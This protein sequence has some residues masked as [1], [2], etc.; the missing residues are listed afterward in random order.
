MLMTWLITAGTLLVAVVVIAI[1]AVG[2]GAR[3]EKSHGELSQA[4]AEATKHLNGEA[5][6][7]K[8]LVELFGAI[9]DPRPSARSA[10]SAGAL[11]PR[12]AKEAVR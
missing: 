8:P 9:P 6:P 4:M 3:S 11:A 5:E 7:P 2:N 10:D 12:P 1:V